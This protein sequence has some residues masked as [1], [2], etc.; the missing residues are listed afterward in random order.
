MSDFENNPEE[1]SGNETPE[2]VSQSEN[3]NTYNASNQNP[4]NTWNAADPNM[5]NTWNAADPNMA[6]PY[7]YGEGSAQI[8]NV[9]QRKKKP[10]W[11]FVLL[12]LVAVAGICTA[13][14]LFVPTIRNTFD[15]I[16]LS[17]ASYYKKV[18]TRNLD[19]KIDKFTS[20]LK[21]SSELLNKDLS[22]SFNE[23]MVFGD[24]YRTLLFSENANKNNFKLNEIGMEGSYSKKDNRYGANT[25]ISLNGSSVASLDFYID[26]NYVFYFRI[27][28]LSDNYISMD[29]KDII[30]GGLTANLASLPGDDSSEESIKVMEEIMKNLSKAEIDYDLLNSILKRYSA[31]SI[32]NLG[33]VKMEKGV[34]LSDDY[35]NAK[36]TKLTI[37]VTEKDFY[38]IVLAILE[39]MKDDSEVLDFVNKIYPVTKEQYD[40]LFD[41]LLTNMKEVD[42]GDLDTQEPVNLTVWTDSSGAVVGRGIDFDGYI[43]S[44]INISNKNKMGCQLKVS[45]DEEN[46]AFTI[47]GLLENKNGSYNGTLSISAGA[48]GANL[49]IGEIVINNYYYKNANDYEVDASVIIKESIIKLIAGES[50]FPEGVSGDIQLSMKYSS[51]D[52]KNIVD[53]AYGFGAPDNF[54]SVH[55]DGEIGDAKDVTIPSESFK[56]P[57]EFNEYEKTLNYEGFIKNIGSAIGISDEDINEAIE[58]L[59][60]TQG[61]IG[62]DSINPDSDS[63]ADTDEPSVDTPSDIDSDSLG[64][65][66]YGEDSENMVNEIPTKAPTS[67]D[68]LPEG[69][70]DDNGYYSYNVSKE[71]VEKFGQPDSNQHFDLT[72]DDVES[73]LMDI[74]SEYIGET[75]VVEE[76]SDNTIS[77]TIDEN[78]AYH[79]FSFITSK[80]LS[81]NDNAYTNSFT[82][83]YDTASKQIESI[84]INMSDDNDC[85]NAA[86]Q[87]LSLFEPGFNAEDMEKLKKDIEISDFGFTKFKS[88]NVYYFSMGDSYYSYNI[89]PSTQ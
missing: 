67:A 59:Q 53:Y 74:L 54:M 82:V 62:I 28:E 37:S 25:N 15:L 71:A 34:T 43:L 9:N 5:Q 35:L 18:E 22:Y 66:N 50:A 49:N 19:K 68:Q 6:Q 4:Q 33:K 64:D 76:Q 48:K 3:T 1:F 47:G 42:T 52:N 7:T 13:L 20:E 24:L 70:K 58:A 85:D 12:G 16:T 65:N 39:K 21:K 61:S 84:V 46:F 38:N 40:S 75:S 8:Y 45:D 2:N 17:P 55:M 81:N 88:V 51:K 78:Y 26:E 14:V 89:S 80:Q 30:K 29:F 56:M 32:E 23:T 31:I 72:Y 57:D 10:V 36:T 86:T 83:N 60:K 11:A 77:G 44:A 63:P 79:Y 87:V 73:K 41:K 27:P 69:V